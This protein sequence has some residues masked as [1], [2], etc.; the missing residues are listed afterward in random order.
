MLP[1]DN[2]FYTNVINKRMCWVQVIEKNIS[3]NTLA[4]LARLPKK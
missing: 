4:S 1:D 3:I 2:L